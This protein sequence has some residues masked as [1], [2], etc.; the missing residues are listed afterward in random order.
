MDTGHT[1]DVNQYAPH[2]GVFRGKC[3]HFAAGCRG[4]VAVV[5]GWLSLFV[6]LFLFLS[7][8]VPVWIHRVVGH[9]KG[10]DF[11]GGFWDV[12]HGFVFSPS[13]RQHLFDRVSYRRFGKGQ[14]LLLLLVL[15]PLVVFGAT[16]G[17]SGKGRGVAF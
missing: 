1:K 2:A 11:G 10:N 4:S 8:F 5:V 14:L 17:G 6:V 3:T 7:T 9:T 15:V 12:V 13:F 16:A